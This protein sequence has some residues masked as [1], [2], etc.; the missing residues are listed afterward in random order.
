MQEPRLAKKAG[1]SLENLSST[2]RSVVQ[3]VRAKREAIA[4]IVAALNRAG[5]FDEALQA[6]ARL[7]GD[8]AWERCVANIATAAADGG[9]IGLAEKCFGEVKSQWRK[10]DVAPSIVAALAKLGRFQEASELTDRTQDRL[11][12]ASAIFNLATAHAIR[13]D[14]R[15]VQKE[16]DRV[17]VSMRGT[18]GLVNDG[19]REI[20]ADL[21]A[22]VTSQRPSHLPNNSKGH[23][24]ARK[25][26]S[27]PPTSRFVTCIG[28]S[29]PRSIKASVQ[30]RRGRASGTSRSRCL[31]E[32]RQLR[33]T[34]IP[35]GRSC[36]D[37][38]RLRWQKRTRVSR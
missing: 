23:S 36:G 6:A 27:R 5:R 3:N 38:G 10:D 11:K 33:S 29:F 31:T 19:Q 13:G 9:R 8:L 28:N 25:P 21:S 17:M 18:W 26:E 35:V 20:V 7:K 1:R 15:S 2:E 24:H 30:Q 4:V 37:S 32:A 16:Y 14:E 22:T 12:K 34:P